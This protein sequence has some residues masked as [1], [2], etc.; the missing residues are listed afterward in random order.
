M[1]CLVGEQIE[2][3]MSK[4]RSETH[5]AHDPKQVLRADVEVDTLMQFFRARFTCVALMM[6]PKE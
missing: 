6:A 4:V 1:I 3:C 5:M 2:S